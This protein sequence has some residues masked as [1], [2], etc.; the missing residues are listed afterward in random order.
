MELLDIAILEHFSK[1][2]FVYAFRSFSNIFDRISV[3]FR[4]SFSKFTK[5][6]MVFFGGFRQLNGS[7][8]AVSFVVIVLFVD[9]FI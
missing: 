6:L 3:D 2:Y 5:T 4:E 9:G 1:I 8:V 7:M